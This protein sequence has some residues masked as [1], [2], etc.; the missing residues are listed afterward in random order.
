MGKVQ[1]KRS[2]DITTEPSNEIQVGSGELKKIDDP[3]FKENDSSVSVAFMLM[4]RKTRYEQRSLYCHPL[5][6]RKQGRERR[7][8]E[9][10]E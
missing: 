1:S 8:R 4:T 7:R 5:G 10:E 9:R 6:Q 3:H 2:A